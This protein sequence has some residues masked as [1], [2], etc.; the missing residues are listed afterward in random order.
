MDEIEELVI[1]FG[2]RD[3]SFPVQ[4]NDKISFTFREKGKYGQAESTREVKVK[5]VFRMIKEGK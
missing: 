1:W 4:P 5:E 3:L 2:K